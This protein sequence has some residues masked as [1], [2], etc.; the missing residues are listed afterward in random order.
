MR[1]TGAFSPKMEKNT[2]HS[3]KNNS[4]NVFF[5]PNNGCIGANSLQHC[6]CNTDISQTLLMISLAT[7]RPFG[8]LLKPSAADSDQLHMESGAGISS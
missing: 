8:T 7:A 4:H 1:G 3:G 5:P 2:L 6:A